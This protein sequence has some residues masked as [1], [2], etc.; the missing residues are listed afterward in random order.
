MADNSIKK[1]EIAKEAI[2]KKSEEAG[3]ISIKG[4]DFNKKFDFSEFLKSYQSTGFQASNLARAIEIIKKMRKEKAFIYLGYTSNIISSGLREVIRYLAEHK[5]VDVLVTTAGG[6][7]EDFVKCLGDFKL[8]TFNADGA[9]LREKGINRI[10]NI[11]VPNSRYIK[12]EEFVLDI[13]KDY[14]NEIL[15]P[16]KLIRILGEKINNKD[17]IYYWCAKN[18]IQV[19]CPAIMDGSLGDMI[20]F[21]KS[22]NRQFKLDITE[23]TWDLNNS[24][25]GKEKT[26]MIIL[27]GGVVKHSICNANLYRNGAD[28]AIYIN[29]N[30]EFDGSDSGA[31][32]EEAKSWGKITGKGESVKV[33]GDATIIFPLLVA[34][35]F[36]DSN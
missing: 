11:F 2:L 29:S 35:A 5:L 18:N 32:P 10:G 12:F 25:I 6:I 21:F 31:S 27:G 36:K 13:L 19:F 20:Y 8:G 26:G 3:G 16:S 22:D 17:S 30:P 1:V 4:F 33:F 9:M 24:T 34:G 14:K 15:T 7:E 28:Y 23:D